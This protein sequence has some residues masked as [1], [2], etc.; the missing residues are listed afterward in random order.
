MTTNRSGSYP[1]GL[2]RLFDIVFASLGLVVLS[3]VIVLVSIAIVAET[4]WPI[5]FAQTRLGVGGRHFR[6]YKFRKFR[7][8]TGKSL[9]LTM[10][11]DD[12]MTKV[13][14]FLAKSKLDE[15]PQLFNILRGEM[16]V[17]GPRPE[18]LELADCFTDTTRPVL[19]HKP[20]IFGPSQCAFRNESAFYPPDVDPVAFYRQTL[21]PAKARLDLSYYPERTLVSDMKWIVLCCLAILG[22]GSEPERAIAAAGVTDGPELR[23]Q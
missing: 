3:P 15:V 13:G 18:S 9:P 7:P 12:R 16:A 22:I 5:L 1:A 20:G 19:A 17:V 14:R 6:M 11:A 10:Q 21:F 8:D 4:G 2:A 23:L